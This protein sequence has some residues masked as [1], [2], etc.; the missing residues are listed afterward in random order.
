[1]KVLTYYG[2][3]IIPVKKNDLIAAAIFNDLIA[4]VNNFNV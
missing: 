1:M 3:S 4:A 2:Y